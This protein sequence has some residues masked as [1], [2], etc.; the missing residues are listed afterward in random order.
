[1]I[2]GHRPS[3]GLR[4]CRTPIEPAACI[5]LLVA[6]LRRMHRSPRRA[7]PCAGSAAADAGE[8]PCGDVR[9]PVVVA[10][11][12]AFGRLTLFA[13]V[14][15]ARFGP[16]Q[17]VEREELAEF[18]VVGHAAGV[19]ERL[20]DVASSRRAPTRPARTRRAA[21][22]SC[23]RASRRPASVRDIPTSSQSTAPTAR[24]KSRID[25]VP[26]TREEASDPLLRGRGRFFEAVVIG[27]DGWQRRG[28]QVV[29][30]R[31]RDHEVAVGQALHER[32]G[33][34]A[35]C[36]VVARSW[37]RRARAGPGSVLIRL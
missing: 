30:N 6:P 13:E 4:A 10:Q 33:A 21:S 26:L 18:E 25:R 15:A 12:F 9:E 22:G 34:E 3:C 31:V 20:V 7:V 19:V 35:V 29:A 16:V 17:R 28:R 1:M 36:A 11:R 23:S 37:L 27:R 32:A 8:L 5:R 2:S 24:W 14:S